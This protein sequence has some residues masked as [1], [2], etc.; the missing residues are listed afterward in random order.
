MTDDLIF[1]GSNDGLIRLINIQPHEMVGVIGDQ[2]DYP[3]EKLTLNSDRDTLPSVSHD[4][5][6]RLW[7]VKYVLDPSDDDASIDQDEAQEAENDAGVDE[8]S[9]SEDEVQVKKKRKSNAKAKLAAP[10]KRNTSFFAGL[11]GDDDDQ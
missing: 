8:A 11:E 9:S 3:I 4:S 5:T 6:I 1:T 2:G 10:V 7:D